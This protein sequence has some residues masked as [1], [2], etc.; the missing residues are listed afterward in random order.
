VRN[1]FKLHKEVTNSEQLDKF[2]Y[3]W[4]Q[5]LKAM[6]EAPVIDGSI[7]KIGKDL[8]KEEINLLTAEQKAKLEELRRETLAS[9]HP[10][11]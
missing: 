11:S 9:R 2:F 5:Y 4:K 8:E 1:E 10:Q 7:G 3:E 6:D